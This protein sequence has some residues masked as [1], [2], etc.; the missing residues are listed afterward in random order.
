MQDATF[1]ESDPGHGRT[2]KGDG[3]IPVDPEFLE[4]PPDEEKYMDM[5]GI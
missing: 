4:T 1:I 5:G 2:R 3:A